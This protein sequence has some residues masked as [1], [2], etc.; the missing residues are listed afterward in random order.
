IARDGYASF[1]RPNLTIAHLKVQEIS[2]ITAFQAA[3]AANARKPFGRNVSRIATMPKT[4]PTGARASTR[5]APPKF[6]LPPFGKAISIIIVVTIVA[7]H[8][9][10]G[11]RNQNIRRALAALGGG[12]IA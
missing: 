10:P 11:R 12:G 1:N 2:T 3:P 9:A 8:V 7:M 6:R 5:Q 4:N